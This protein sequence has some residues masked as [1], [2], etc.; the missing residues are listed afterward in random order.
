MRILVLAIHFIIYL[1][2]SL[3]ILKVNNDFFFFKEKF[4]RIFEEGSGG[5]G[6]VA[7]LDHVVSQLMSNSWS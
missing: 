4:R 5:G 1:F 3:L 2:K 7:F 6:G